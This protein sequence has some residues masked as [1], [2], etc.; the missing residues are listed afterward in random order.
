MK[1]LHCDGQRRM[2]SME[3]RKKTTPASVVPCYAAMVILPS[4]KAVD[5]ALDT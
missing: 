4:E 5:L 1:K 2:G 3:M